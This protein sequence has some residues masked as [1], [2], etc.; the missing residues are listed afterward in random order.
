[1]SKDTASAVCPAH[2]T[3]KRFAN[4]TMKYLK[5]EMKMA[6]ICTTN[7]NEEKKSNETRKTS[8]TSNNHIKKYRISV[9]TE[10]RRENFIT[11]L[12]KPMETRSPNE[13]KTKRKGCDKQKG[14]H[15]PEVKGKNTPRSDWNMCVIVCLAQL[16]C[17][18]KLL[19]TSRRNSLVENVSNRQNG[20]I[21]KY[22]VY[23]RNQVRI[24]RWQYIERQGILKRKNT[25]YIT[26]R[27]DKK[28]TQREEQPQ[29]Y[30]APKAAGLGRTGRRFIPDPP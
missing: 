6:V 23:S 25:S 8:E 17:T 12:N 24:G 11:M 18:C 13:L 20:K 28:T 29:E 14:I 15:L 4:E 30:T 16:R 21:D 2:N 19:Q 26:T 22:Q 7:E 10:T 9:S 3:K 1:M 5:N 27:D